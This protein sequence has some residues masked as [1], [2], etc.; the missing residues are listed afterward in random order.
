MS[1]TQS[2]PNPFQ[3]VLG[4]GQ[5]LDTG[6]YE[7]EVVQL[8]AH[9][10]THGIWAGKT[11]YGKSRALCAFAI[12]LLKHKI[13]FTLIDPAG[14]LARLILQ[15]LLALGYFDHHPDPFT[16]LIYLDIP[17]ALRQ[18]Q[19]LPFNVL[20]TAH[21]PYTAA[22]LVLEAF[23]RTFPSL[24]S[25]GSAVNI[26]TLL[27]LSAFV[28]ASHNLPLLPHMSLLLGD[29]A[30]RQALLASIG[31]ELVLSFFQQLTSVRSGE[32]T[33]STESTN[34][35]LFLLGFAPVLRYSL[36]Q[37]E[38][39]L[40]FQRLIPQGKCVVINLNV[41]DLEAMRFLGSLVTVQAETGAKARGQLR[42][43]ERHGI[44]ILLCD[45]FHNFCSQSGDA[46]AHMLAECRKYGLFLQ[47]AFQSYSQLPDQLQGALLNC[48]MRVVY[49]QELPDAR[50]SAELLNVPIDPYLVKPSL[51]TSPRFYTPSEQR[52]MHVQAITRLAKQEAIVRLPGD[53]LYKMQTI[54]VP[55][56]A[57]DHKQREAVEAEYLRRYF[58]PRP[59]LDVLAPAT[60]QLPAHQ[61]SSQPVVVPR[62]ELW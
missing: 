17:T 61:G 8:P 55:D 47:G 53:R 6:K 25:A 23:R 37:Q 20:H 11:G 34:K 48:D 7:R 29:A 15:Q 62:E 12:L 31:D 44:H 57:V 18:E 51:S 41:P 30:Y 38:N 19:Y 54:S 36:G 50:K 42:P 49:R 28:L 26:E 16:Q 46:F 1:P 24:R 40:D 13:G 58:R 27:K 14:D 59:M 21:D 22:D 4:T 3:L 43:E 33:I 9:S 45:E 60:L 52:E 39:L 32:L 35:R 56:V 5:R 2:Q 10:L